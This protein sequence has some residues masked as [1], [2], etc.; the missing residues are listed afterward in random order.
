V[1]RPDA[2]F[3]FEESGLNRACD[4]VLSR[5]GINR[6]RYVGYGVPHCGR[7][8]LGGDAFR[9]YENGVSQDIKLFRREDNPVAVGLVVDNSSSMRRKV[10]DVVAPDLAFVNLS[11]PEDQMFIV[12]FNEHVSFALPDGTL[13]TSDPSGL[14]SAMLRI[15]AFTLR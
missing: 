6:G 15:P 13:F 3:R 7:R 11:N 14:R 5:T 10:P 9:V 4:D 2:T 8:S 1:L 12:N